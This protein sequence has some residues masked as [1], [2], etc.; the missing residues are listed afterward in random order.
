MRIRTQNLVAIVP[1]V[2]G[3]ALAAG[4][5]AYSTERKKTI[6]GLHEE[7]TSL[8]VAMAEFTDGEA[9][10]A[11]IGSGGDTAAHFDSLRI[12]FDRVIAHGQAKHIFA[13]TRVG[14]PMWAVTEGE[15]AWDVN[16]A[17]N[18]SYIPPDDLLRPT[19]AEMD[20]LSA[21][22]T[23]VVRE[24]VR[25]PGDIAVMTAFAPIAA[26]NGDLVGILGVVIDAERLHSLARALP[27]S[28]GRLALIALLIGTLTSLMTSSAS[29]A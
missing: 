6:E 17:A 18:E 7:A 2:V 25:L 13:L 28:L 10:L 19:A 27:L 5:L 20:Q 4:A 26:A 24:V 12:S 29:H 15:P 3:M 16:L 11:R 22:S 1:L 23:P 9:L 8:A 14:S 21:A